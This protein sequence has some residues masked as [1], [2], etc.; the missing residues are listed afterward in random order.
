MHTGQVFDGI[1]GGTLMSDGITNIPT[2]VVVP[3]HRGRFGVLG[4]REAKEALE[5][6]MMEG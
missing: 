5:T 2:E 4:G 6:A 1:A 3:T